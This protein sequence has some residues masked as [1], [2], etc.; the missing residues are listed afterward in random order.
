MI[1]I[2]T[3]CRGLTPLHVFKCCGVSRVPQRHAAA[4]RS[5]PL[6]RGRLALPAR[7]R[8]AAH[9]RSTAEFLEGECS[10]W[11]R[12]N[13]WC[14]NTPLVAPCDFFFFGDFTRKVFEALRSFANEIDLI[15]QLHEVAAAYPVDLVQKAIHSQT[16]GV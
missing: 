10:D 1:N 5:S 8:T 13:E 12:P 6:P 4:R 16:R 9:G 2:G 3:S 7:Q 15:A 11:I 14:S